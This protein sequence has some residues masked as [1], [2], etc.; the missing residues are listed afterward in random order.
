MGLQAATPALL[1]GFPYTSRCQFGQGQAKPWMKAPG[2]WG[3]THPEDVSRELVQVLCALWNRLVGPHR[4]F[5]LQREE[6][7][8]PTVRKD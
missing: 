8:K 3:C 6:R 1:L 4:F 5:F 7:R 2:S